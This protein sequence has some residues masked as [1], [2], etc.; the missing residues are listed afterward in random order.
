MFNILSKTVTPQEMLL[1]K[2]LEPQG[3]NLSVRPSE[4]F[5][6]DYIFCV[7]E[8]FNEGKSF[9]DNGN[10]KKAIKFSKSKLSELLSDLTDKQSVNSEVSHDKNE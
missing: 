8:A 5:S 3:A 9:L 10:L 6:Q 2:S 4:I 7:I 1:L